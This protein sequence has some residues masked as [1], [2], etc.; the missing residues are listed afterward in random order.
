MEVRKNETKLSAAFE[1]SVAQHW[2]K[3]S[4]GIPVKSR[5]WN[6]IINYLKYIDVRG[7]VSSYFACRVDH[8]HLTDKIQAQSR[9]AFV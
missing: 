1:G 7:T 9:E 6:Y 5:E 3:P 2:K 4:L 8:A